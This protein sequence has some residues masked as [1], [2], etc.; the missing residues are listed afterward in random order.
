[1]AW[2]PSDKKRKTMPSSCFLCQGNAP[3]TVD[4]SFIRDVVKCRQDA[5]YPVVGPDQVE[6]FGMLKAN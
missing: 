4:G 3:L 6:H 2:N 1:M 5:D